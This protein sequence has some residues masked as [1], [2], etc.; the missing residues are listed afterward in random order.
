MVTT[1]PTAFTTGT[2]FW[3]ETVLKEKN[4]HKENKDLQGLMTGTG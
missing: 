4:V 3:R 1:G 2:S